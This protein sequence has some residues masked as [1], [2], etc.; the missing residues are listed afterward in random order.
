MANSNAAEQALPETSL[1]GLADIQ[2]PL[3]ANDWYLAPGWSLLLILLV[4]LLSYLAYRCWRYRQWQ[5][6]VKVALAALA[7]LDLTTADAAEQITRLMKRLLLTRQSAH[8]AVAFSG[9]AWQQYLLASLPKA[10][11]PA[12]ALPDLQALH[13]QSAPPIA[14]IK[15]YAA[16]AALWLKKVNLSPQPNVKKGNNHA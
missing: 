2:E 7:E 1:P 5:Q 14:D 8:P 3:L 16:F 9:T 12:D 13:Y 10:D 11:L 15:R 4:A 6:P